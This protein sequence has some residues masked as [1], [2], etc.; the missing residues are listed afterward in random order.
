MRKYLALTL[1]LA[2]A[3]MVGSL[4]ATASGA[5]DIDP[6]D[7]DRQRRQVRLVRLAKAIFSIVGTPGTKYAV[8][9][10]AGDEVADGRLDDAA[11][12]FVCRQR[13][14]RT[15]RR[16]R[17]RRHRQRRVRQHRSGLELVAAPDSQLPNCLGPRVVITMRGLCNCAQQFGDLLQRKRLRQQCRRTCATRPRGIDS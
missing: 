3:V 8:Y 17:V 14:H 6:A 1:V 13:W 2:M 4:R 16:D 10:S 7:A 5:E 15:E 12:T 9:D 11:V